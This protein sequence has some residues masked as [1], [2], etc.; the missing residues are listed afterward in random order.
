[1]G[2][3]DLIKPEPPATLPWFGRGVVRGA[4]RSWTIT[5]PRQM[6][7]AEHAWYEFAI[8]SS[9]TASFVRRVEPA[10]E[11]LRYQVRG[12]LVGD[13]LISDDRRVDPDPAKIVIQSER[14]HL[15][16]DGLDRF[17]RVCAGR[18]HERGRLIYMAPEMPL[19]SEY[20]VYQAFLDR[21]TS[22]DDVK[23]VPPALDAAFRME[24]HQ[25][26]ETER[27][28]AEAA[29]KLEELEAARLLEEKRKEV[30]AK[31][32]DGAGRRLA[33]RVD[34][35]GAARA[36]LAVGGA[37]F[38]D[39]VLLRRGEYAVKFRLS[40][41][42]FECTCDPNLQIISS[43]ICLTDSGSGEK[44]DDRFTLESL[45]SVIME[46]IR[47]DVLVVYRHV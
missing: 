23:G 41:R 15:L 46:A 37:E 28:R 35:D 27:R 33:A 31:F 10:P 34:F 39:S 47:T 22:V 11:L 38:L 24:T 14:V 45:P 1:M 44:G 30:V 36:A 16:E 26:I 25:R 43:G 42:R 40:G 13:R 12:Y 7:P 8:K 4:N 19:G 17:A 5:T 9:G 18:I 21:K 29:R 32:G 20:A 6:Y 3:R 2:W